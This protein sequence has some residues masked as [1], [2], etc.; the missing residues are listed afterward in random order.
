MTEEERRAAAAENLA[1]RRQALR[2]K[3]RAR[4]LR[5]LIVLGLVLILL[6]GAVIIHMA[7]AHR[8]SKAQDESAAGSAEETASPDIVIGLKGSAVQLV[9]QG[10]PYIENGAFAIDRSSGAIPG[11]DIKI[12]GKV[13]TSKPGDYEI[14]Y[15]AG[16]GL[17]AKTA[18]RTVRVVTEEDYGAAAEDVPV[19]MYHWV[20]NEN[21]VP[22]KLDAN[23]L[24]DTD[25]DE[26]LTYLENE[27]FYYPG[28]KELR[29]WIDD[30]ITLPAK[31]VVLTFDDGKEAFL[32]YGVPVLEKHQIPATSFMICWEKN[33]GAEKVRKYASEYIDYESHTYAMHQKSDNPNRKGID[34]NMTKEEIA[35]DLAQAAAITGNNDAIAYPYGDYCD[36]F[37]D[38]AREQGIIVGFTT[39]YERVRK[40]ADPMLLPRIR[41]LGNES[42]EY[43]KGT[44]W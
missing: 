39:E 3:N 29:A 7:K 4:K 9:L 22:E 38:A 41:V 14:T 21:D 1:R 10:D 13:D 12:K 8:D 34:I 18:K 17:S 36:N 33:K 19:M 24:L 32:K 27:G 16:K 31:S 42:L 25:L 28:W 30:E 15:K 37:L 5:A 26:Q 11:E 2:K 40:G 35:S 44:V 20:Y 43:W 23:W 6:L